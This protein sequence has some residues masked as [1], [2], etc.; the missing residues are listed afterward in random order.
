MTTAESIGA[1]S[2]WALA[3]AVA[4]AAPAVKKRRDVED[5]ADELDVGEQDVLAPDVAAGPHPQRDDEPD[6]GD[7]GEG[8]Q[9]EPGEGQAAP[10]EVGD[11]FGARARAA[12]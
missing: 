6:E 11:R 3:A 10:V 5:A 12:R 4:V 2:N 1:P 9:V 7:P 8:H